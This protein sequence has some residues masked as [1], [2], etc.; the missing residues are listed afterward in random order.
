MTNIYYLLASGP[1]VQKGRAGT[2]GKDTTEVHLRPHSHLEVHW[3]EVERTRSAPSAWLLASE[4]PLTGSL[5]WLL[6]TSGPGWLSGGRSISWGC[7]NELPQT[8]QL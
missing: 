6:A 4:D 3:A 1:E 2:S 5:V 8:G 7:R